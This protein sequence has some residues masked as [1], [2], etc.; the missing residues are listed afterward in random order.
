[1]IHTHGSGEE[2]VMPKVVCA[3]IGIVSLVWKGQVISAVKRN[4]NME[5]R[6]QMK[7]PVKLAPKI[8]SKARPQKIMLQLSINMIL[9]LNKGK[10]RKYNRNY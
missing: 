2:S 8:M 4:G 7:W 3:D 9:F 10:F 5:K 1:M 6:E